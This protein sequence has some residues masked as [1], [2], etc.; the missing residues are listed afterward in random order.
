MPKGGNNKWLSEFEILQ[1]QKHNSD[2]EKQLR[3]KSVA[4]YCLIELTEKGV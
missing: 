1:L 2:L 4:K 3:E